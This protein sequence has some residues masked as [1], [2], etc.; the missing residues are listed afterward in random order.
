MICTVLISFG[1]SCKHEKKQN[2]EPVTI[3]KSNTYRN[4][5]KYPNGN[6]KIEGDI[7]NGI[8]QGNW[9]SYY[10]NGNKWSECNYDFGDKNGIYRTYYSNGNPKIHGIYKKN[11]KV[12]VWFF[13]NEK[14]QFE[15]EVD[16]TKTESQ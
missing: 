1:Y 11:K 13:Y 8:R 6:I 15:K 12:D 7:V 3:E 16:F 2:K 9:I 14:G 10:E 4:I 5:E